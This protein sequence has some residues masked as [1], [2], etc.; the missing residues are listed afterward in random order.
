MV[1]PDFMAGRPP[2]ALVEAALMGVL[3]PFQTPF[4][5]SYLPR[6]ESAQASQSAWFCHLPL[7]LASFPLCF[8]LQKTYLLFKLPC[9]LEVKCLHR[10]ERDFE[11]R[12][13]CHSVYLSQ[14]LLSYYLRMRV[15][16]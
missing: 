2:L 10:I 6:R 16:I 9:G 12:A 14:V 4:G 3:P 8:R 1:L 7:R 5:Q 15:I 11:I 13:D